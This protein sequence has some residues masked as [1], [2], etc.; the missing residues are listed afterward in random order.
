VS[1]IPERRGPWDAEKWP[2]VVQP[3]EHKVVGLRDL[4]SQTGNTTTGGDGGSWWAPLLLSWVGLV[5]LALVLTGKPG[6]LRA[7]S[8]IGYVMTVP[9]L[10]CIRLLSLPDRLLQ[11][12]FGVGL[13]LALAV[14]VAQAMIYLEVWS[15]VR[16]ITVLVVIASLASCGELLIARV[17]HRAPPQDPTADRWGH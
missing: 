4:P 3:L 13:S 2:D 5:V 10:A 6:P 17:S 9:G 7:V 1:A 11:L 12:V 15:P 14:L 8:V 16:G